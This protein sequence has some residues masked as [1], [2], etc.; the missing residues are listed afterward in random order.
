MCT[1][2]LMP[3]YPTWV[4]EGNK[5]KPYPSGEFW[6]MFQYNTFSII[7]STIQQQQHIIYTYCTCTHVISNSSVQFIYILQ[8]KKC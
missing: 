6:N 5:K 8:S 2:H 1:Y 7:Y 3:A 4:I